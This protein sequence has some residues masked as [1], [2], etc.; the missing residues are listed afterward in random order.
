MVGTLQQMPTIGTLLHVRILLEFF[1]QPY[2][3]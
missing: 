3:F 2:W 1:C